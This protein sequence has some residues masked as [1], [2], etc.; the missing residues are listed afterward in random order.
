VFIEEVKEMETVEYKMI[1]KCSGTVW[2]YFFFDA[3]NDEVARNHAKRKA[4]SY[5]A[6]AYK[7]E[8]VTK[9]RII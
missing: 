4:E 6:V 7:V 3:P 1:Y 5:N 9:E 2:K 8:K